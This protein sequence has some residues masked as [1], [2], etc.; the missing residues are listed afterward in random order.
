[1]QSRPNALYGGRVSFRGSM[2]ISMQT[3]LSNG[4]GGSGRVGSGLHANLRGIR[5]PYRA[6]AGSANAA[7][8]GYW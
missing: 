5:F 2:L 6:A 3:L 1:M 4:F 7:T 8:C